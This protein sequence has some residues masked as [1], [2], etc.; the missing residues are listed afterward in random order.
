MAYNTIDKEYINA[1]IESYEHTCK[2]AF[3]SYEDYYTDKINLLNKKL[4]KANRKSNIRSTYGG[5]RKKLR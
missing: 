2:Q 4:M 3:D 5:W 1:E